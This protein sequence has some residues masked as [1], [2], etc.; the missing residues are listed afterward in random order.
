MQKVLTS[1]HCVPVLADLCAL[2]V[3][4]WAASC[5]K[6]NS[7]RKQPLCIPRRLYCRNCLTIAMVVFALPWTSHSIT[8]RPCSCCVPAWSMLLGRQKESFATRQPCP[9]SPRE[10]GFKDRSDAP[11]GSPLPGFTGNC[12]TVQT[13]LALLSLAGVLAVTDLFCVPF[14]K[15]VFLWVI[16][17]AW[18]LQALSCWSHGLEGASQLGWAPA[19]AFQGRLKA[20]S[21]NVWHIPSWARGAGLQPCRDQLQEPWISY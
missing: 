4:L 1:Y 6:Q 5:W 7:G 12:P 19:A 3:V 16:T 21:Q 2:H 8:A 10:M 15:S 11:Q 9:R 20:P 17:Q 18:F 13:E 14:L